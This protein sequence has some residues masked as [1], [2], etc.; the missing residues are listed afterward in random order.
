MR[1]W[2]KDLIKY[3]PHQQ[4]LGQWRECCC[5][6]KNIKDNGTPNHM[7]VNKISDYSYLHFLKYSY[8]ILQEM[9]RRSY[10]ISENSVQQLSSNILSS[11]EK[12]AKVT[13]CVSRNNLFENWHTPRYL[14]QCYFNL[15]EKFDNGG[16]PEKEWMPVKSF[17]E[18]FIKKFSRKLFTFGT[19][20]DII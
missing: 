9:R 13:E 5:I 20:C 19:K 6:A 8:M 7:L 15:Q 14:T 1:I 3:L 16:I 2:H 17:F 18:K 11:T 10:N 12:Y 4:L